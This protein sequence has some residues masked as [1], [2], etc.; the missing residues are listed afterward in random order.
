MVVDMA[1]AMLMR[2]R[3]ILTLQ[4]IPM[5]LRRIPM[6]RLISQRMCSHLMATARESAST[7]GMVT[8]MDMVA[9]IMEVTGDTTAATVRTMVV[10]AV[11]SVV[12]MAATTAVIM[13]VITDCDRRRSPALSK[14]AGL[15]DVMCHNVLFFNY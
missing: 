4:H 11:I 9:V 6:L 2:L 15:P 8:R 5:L 14:R 7:S 10:T 3:C 12:I 13:V 1:V